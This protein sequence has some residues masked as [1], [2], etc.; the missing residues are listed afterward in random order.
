MP[1]LVDP[2]DFGAKIIASLNDDENK[3]NS[4]LP[5]QNLLT[6]LYNSEVDTGSPPFIS[7]W[8]KLNPKNVLSTFNN[9]LEQGHSSELAGVTNFLKTRSF[10]GNDDTGGISIS[11]GGFG[12]QLPQGTSFAIG[13]NNASASLFRGQL[14]PYVN[15]GNNPTVGAKFNLPFG[16]PKRLKSMSPPI[17]NRPIENPNYANLEIPQMREDQ[18]LLNKLLKSRGY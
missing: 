8:G 9:S 2:E 15:W 4:L 13:P 6:N 10:N 11:P 7:Q 3:S 5:F 12:V 1:T 16:P 14:T 18:N 17:D